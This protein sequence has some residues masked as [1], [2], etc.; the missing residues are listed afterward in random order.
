M[1]SEEPPQ[2]GSSSNSSVEKED[3]FGYGLIQDRRRG[4]AKQEKSFLHNS[5]FS[6]N[7]KCQLML[8]IALNTSKCRSPLG[9]AKQRHC[10]LWIWV[11]FGQGRGAPAYPR[12]TH[13]LVTA[14]PGSFLSLALAFEELFFLKIQVLFQRS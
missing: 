1:A 10:F 3:D 14:L 5:L 13:V 11:V 2:S 8:K 7:Y 6:F 12:R 9:R 4:E